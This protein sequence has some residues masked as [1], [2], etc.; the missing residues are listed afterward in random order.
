MATPYPKR[1][2]KDINEKHA[3]R[4]KLASDESQTQAR[5]SKATSED[6]LQWNEV[7]LPDRLD[8][9]EGFFGLEEISDVEVVKH[10]KHGRVEYRVGEEI[11]NSKHIKPPATA[12]LRK[13]EETEWIGFEDSAPAADGNLSSSGLKS[14]QSEALSSHKQE[15]SSD[16][17]CT[18]NIDDLTEETPFDI[19]NGIPD[20]E[21]GVDGKPT[22][23]VN[24][25]ALA[26][27]T[28]SA[29]HIL[30]LSPQVLAS[31]AKLRFSMPTPIQSSAIPEI[32]DGHDLIGKA[33]TG[34]G[35]TLAFGIPILEHYMEHVTDSDCGRGKSIDNRGSPTALIVSPTRELAHQL[36]AHLT[37]LC[38]PIASKTPVIATLTG[39]LSLQKQLRVLANADIIVG[40]PGRLWDIISSSKG[41]M[42][43]LKQIK[44]LVLDEADRL[45]SEGHF[46]ELE[47]ILNSLER[48]EDGQTQTP[49]SN[50]G[51]ST[52]PSASERQ[53]LVFSAT[54]ASSLSHKL[55]GHQRSSSAP[56]ETN[57]S[58]LLS[59]LSFRQT[60]KYIDASPTAHLPATL[61]SHLISCSALEKD[62]YLYSLFLLHFP[63]SRVL[64]FAN[65]ISS[66]QR[67]VPLLQ[68][69]NF[70]AQALHSQ[71]PQKARLRA[72]ERFASSKEP[73]GKLG[74][75]GGCILI[76]TDVAARGL[77]IANVQA[78]VHYHL[79]RAADT[80]IHR[81]GRTARKGNAG[82][83]VLLC[84]PEEVAGTRRL[85]A[86]VHVAQSQTRGKNAH[87]NGLRTL[88][89]DRGI[90]ARLKERVALAKKIADAELVKT[91][92]GK[93]D[94]WMRDAAEEL[95]VDI[96][97]EAFP[98]G[99]PGGGKRKGKGRKR[100]EKAKKV[101]KVEVGALKAE[102]RALLSRRVNVGVS[103]R[104][105]TAGGIDV[106]GLLEG[107]GR[108]EFLGRVDGLQN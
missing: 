29:W 71:M 14:R 33:S 15:I 86:Q 58:P 50:R 46:K 57:L 48:T 72:V 8:D 35:K 84:A 65:S 97:D 101:S 38:S 19:L 67:L 91:K 54:L 44:F 78:V 96:D 21:E 43:W 25:H 99:G 36:S 89:I 83:S 56:G 87:E 66:V 64:V 93:E 1:R 59:R 11:S 24:K 10:E 16:E 69:L 40:T 76:A 3:K 27:S 31:L 39:G 30:G 45:L 103:E 41:L 26:K 90:V 18:N 2:H 42:P 94:K 81:S 12:D 62:L 17:Q 105:L 6:A 102:L 9:A 79:P 77:D 74:K 55:S 61:T 23:P 80:Y 28:V 98:A 47:K 32:L 100:E 34:S 37:D 95:G 49:S 22:A 68:N 92:Q 106:E 51:E 63:N 82:V 5:S 75:G 85:V 107:R 108:G 70:N 60:P 88:E 20:V 73:N 52:R 53:T 4:R 104:Y 13:A 7:P